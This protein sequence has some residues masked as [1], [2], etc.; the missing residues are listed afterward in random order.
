MKRD[1]WRDVDWPGACA[2]V[3]ALGISL[4]FATALIMSA[5]ART[6]PINQE[7]ATLL[8]TLG[9]AMA[10]S[11]ATYLGHQI[12][13]KDDMTDQ[14]SDANMTDEQ[15]EEVQRQAEVQE[16]EAVEEERK[17]EAQPVEDDPPAAS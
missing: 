9:G 12:K 10:G 4:G 6:P 13:G 14:G 17:T 16:A 15:R 3:L 11:V 5:S 8:A 7:T 2:F 1:W